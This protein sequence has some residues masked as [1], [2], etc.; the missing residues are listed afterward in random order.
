MLDVE[1]EHPGGIAIIGSE[2]TGEPIGDVVLRKKD[3]VDAS[4]V[5]WLV[6]LHPEDFR[7]GEAG[8]SDV[9]GP[10]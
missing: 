3:L 5:L 8:E 4:E 10:L 7:G 6:V 9:A 1:E 2:F